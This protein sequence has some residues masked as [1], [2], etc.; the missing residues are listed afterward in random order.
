MLQFEAPEFLVKECPL[1]WTKRMPDRDDAPRVACA[2]SSNRSHQPCQQH[3]SKAKQSA[4]LP[5]RQP[6]GRCHLSHALLAPR[7]YW[8]SQSSPNGRDNFCYYSQAVM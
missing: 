7:E 8:T 2:A 3:D 4:K 1:C 6:I 5:A